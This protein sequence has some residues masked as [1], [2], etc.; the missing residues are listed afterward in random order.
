MDMYQAMSAMQN[1]QGTMMNYMMQGMI[2]QHPDI[3]QECQNKFSGK[4][5]RQQVSALRELYKSKGMD[6]D[7]VAR[8]YGVRI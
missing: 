5:R 4:T 6:L 7:A 3:W 8:Q 2:A 1:P